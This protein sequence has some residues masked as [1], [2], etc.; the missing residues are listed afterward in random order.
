MLNP[1]R[2]KSASV[3]G[4]FIATGQLIRR[5]TKINA[6]VHCAPRITVLSRVL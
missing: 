3:N 5:D 1:Y 6:A 2:A 4:A